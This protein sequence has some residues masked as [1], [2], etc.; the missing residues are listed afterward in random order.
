MGNSP[1]SEKKNEKPRVRH[2]TWEPLPPPPPT[3]LS[4]F[5]FFFPDHSV[6]PHFLPQRAHRRRLLPLASRSSSLSLFLSDF[7]S[8]PCSIFLS[9]SRSLF[10]RRMASHDQAPP[11]VEWRRASATSAQTAVKQEDPARR[12]LKSKRSGAWAVLREPPGS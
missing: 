7:F 3:F 5:L 6:P 2:Y 9:L 1:P 11:V 8:L 12:Q 4:F 10:P